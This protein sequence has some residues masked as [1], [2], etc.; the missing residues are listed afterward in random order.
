M[1]AVAEHTSPP[2]ALT[3]HPLQRVGAFALARLAGVKHPEQVGE[4]ELERAV[5][6]MHDDL[7]A[8][9]RLPDSKAPDGFWLA[10]SYLFWPNSKLN[11]TNRNKLS[12]TERRDLL[13]EW[14][15][16]PGPG[17][18]LGVPC[19]L[20]GREAC[21]FYGKVD[22][23]LGAS[24]NY[25]NTTPRGHDGLALCRGCLASFHALPYGC[26]IAGGRAAVLHSWDDQFLQGVVGRQV[27]RM[28]QNAGVAS[29]RFGERRPYARQ[30]AA[31]GRIRAYDERLTAG[32]DLMVFSNSNK[33]PTL[34][35][36]AMSQP[37]AEWVRVTRHRP[38]MAAG[39]RYLVR[40]HHGPKVPGWSALAR[41][42]FDRPRRV[43]SVAAW[44]LRGQAEDLRV[45]P[46]EASGLGIVCGDYAMRVL[47]ME[48]SDA[49]EIR[50]LA[51][52]IAGEA[53]RDES[54]FMKFVVA[55][56]KISELK[57]W[58]RGKAISQVRFSRAAD[59]FISERQWRLLFDS[60]DEQFLHRDLLLICAL[61]EV[62]ALDPKW[63]TDDPAK[64]SELDD[65][66][67]DVEQEGDG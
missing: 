59:A 20:C 13:R 38:D 14:R 67:G 65:D 15:M 29:G 1:T 44:Y 19:A 48:K 61:E 55:G 27:H 50:Q 32:V 3:P 49:D 2:V 18:L 24:V 46:G 5:S 7:Y 26:A 41:N 8:T 12:V 30:V 64:R 25:R 17:D 37:L 35:V 31:L 66:L 4:P 34:D 23:P 52:N 56:R 58:L 9:T 45:P 36:H 39:W 10:A 57:K 22:V 51:K 33:E 60:G 16:L 40:A 63:R 47:D 53:G 54:E 62:Q 6:V 43:V 28:R 21:G 42:L 11:T